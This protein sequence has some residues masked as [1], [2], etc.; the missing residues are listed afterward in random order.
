MAKPL[1]QV[2][3]N[4][5][6][7]SAFKLFRHQG[8][9]ATTTRQIA[10]EAGTERGLLSHYFQ[11]KQ[12]ILFTLYSDFLDCIFHYANRRYQGNDG[13]TMIALMNAL[14]YRI[15]F[16]DDDIIRIFTDILQNHELTRTKIDKTTD[17]YWRTLQSQG[18]LLPRETVAL[19]SMVAIGA[20][21]ELVLAMLEKRLPWTQQQLTGQIT[22]LTLLNLPDSPHNTD[23]MIEQAHS[24]AEQANLQDIATLLHDTCD[25]FTW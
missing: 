1:N 5:I 11:R 15:I 7:S 23:T 25:W 17:V 24:L 13:Y 6:L 14:Y 19:A 16:L 21:S 20:E 9:N 22:R 2:L 3:R 18:M 10:A 12:D 4:R 8:F